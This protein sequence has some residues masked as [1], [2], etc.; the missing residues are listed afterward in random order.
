MDSRWIT[1]PYYCK[2]YKSGIIEVLNS[3]C[4]CYVCD[5]F[6]IHKKVPSDLKRL[7]P[8]VSYLVESSYL[9]T[10]DNKKFQYCEQ[11]ITENIFDLVAAKSNQTVFERTNITIHL[12]K[13]NA[14]YYKYKYIK[15]YKYNYDILYQLSH[16]MYVLGTQM[17]C[18]NCCWCYGTWQVHC[19][20]QWYK[21]YFQRISFGK[22][23]HQ[24]KSVLRGWHNQVQEMKVFTQPPEY[25]NC[26]HWKK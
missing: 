19:Y 7:S 20:L 5:V 22:W 8:E 15:Y 2:E 23:D 3:K 26:L 18:I 10:A 24:I 16:V 25:W 17:A 14:K 9:R 1:F 12:N 11:Y 13:K 4:G 21:V 6:Q